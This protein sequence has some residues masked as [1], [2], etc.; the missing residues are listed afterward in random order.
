M[1]GIDR[2]FIGHASA[3]V[4]LEVER[5]HIR[6]FA[7]AIGDPNPIYVDEAAARAA[8]H[9]TIPAPPTFATALRPNDA[10]E[11]IDIDWRRLLHG[12]QEYRFERPLHAGDRLVLVQRI[13]DIFE[14]A[15]R[16]G[17]MDFIVMETTAHDPDGKLIYT[18][19]STAVIKR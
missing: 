14:K 11:G 6:R 10:R 15:G 5:G 12:E 1:S 17:T 13:K 2:K 4:T 3:P 7:E 18:A 8:G 19:L 16:A 9:P